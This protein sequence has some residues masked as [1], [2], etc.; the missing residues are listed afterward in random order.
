MAGRQPRSRDSGEGGREVPGRSGPKPWWQQATAL[1]SVST[2]GAI[3]G[4]A[5][6][7]G[8]PAELTTP[9]AAGL[10]LLAL[11]SLT[12]PRQAA[13]PAAPADAAGRAAIVNV[14]RYYLKLARARSAAQ[15]EALIWGGVSSDGADHGQSCAAFASLTLA[16]G[17]QAAGQRSWVT[18]GGSYPWPLHEWADVRVDPNPSS[19]SVTSIAQDAR[20]HQR[21]HPLGDGYQPRPGDWALFD[22]HVEVVTSDEGGTLHTI[23]ADSLPGYTV[24]A[25]ALAGP[26]ASHGI[27]GFVDN[28]HLPG[29]A[30]TGPAPA[31][32]APVRRRA[33]KPAP[34]VPGKPPPG[35]TT[36]SPASP[37]KTTPPPPASASIPGLDTTAA[38][39]TPPATGKTAKLTGGTGTP[40]AAGRPAGSRQPPGSAR[41]APGTP[42]P[43]A[44][45][46]IPGLDATAAGAAE[47]AK[48]ASAPRRSRTSPTMPAPN[49][50]AAI[51]G[52]AT[53]SPVTRPGAAD[54]GT[55][56][57]RRSAAATRSAAT[58][59]IPGLAPPGA[60]SAAK[61]AGAARKP[62]STAGKPSGTPAAGAQLP[63]GG[64][65]PR[66]PR[67]TAGGRANIPAALPPGGAT[68]RTHR[69]TAG[70]KANM[71]AAQRA[72][73]DSVAP[74]AIAARHRYG[75]P[76]SVTIAQA[77]QESAWGRSSLAASYHNLFGIKGSGPAGSAWLPTSEYAGGQWV[78]VDA[79]FRAYDNDAQSI[80]DH[81]ELLATSGYYTQAM[82]VRSVPDA[83]ANALTGVYATD[84][85]YGAALISLM[86]LYDLYQYDT[87]PQPQAAHPPAAHASPAS[88]ARRGAPQEAQMRSA[89]NSPGAVRA[90]PEK[91][92]L[93]AWYQPRM[94][95]PVRRAFAETASE[96][97]AHLEPL[98]RDVAG[99]A[100][101]SWMVLAACDWMQCQASPRRSPVHGEKLGQ[102]NPDGLSY[103]TKSAA[104]AQC[105]AD[106]TVLA[107]AV[108]RVD[109]TRTRPL[110]VQE[111]AEVF[112]AFRWGGLLARHGVSA[113]E[114][115][116]SVAGLTSDHMRMHWPAVHDPDP[117]DRPGARFKMPFGAV[118]ALLSLDY[119]ATR[120]PAGP[121]HLY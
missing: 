21:W 7:P 112:A 106:L 22:G 8:T 60:A 11:D 31:S 83:F 119:P 66:T 18:G 68:P 75:V 92:R 76:A 54:P 116:Y 51:P 109:L 41:P 24:N 45:A 97:L 115:P 28:G 47:P 35:G 65:T 61:P 49:A 25:H 70:G 20:E 91:A 3:T 16:L 32:A 69:G 93:A 4:L 29:A 113:M 96:P 46:S 73:I 99:K 89:D 6:A 80:A 19:L 14:A 114:F 104:L 5:F 17:A 2:S 78:T 50:T 13:S 64:A 1:V 105:A 37:A 56:G 44:T 34:A 118:P 53:P 26:P 42:R 36:A 77:I 111:L 101:I 30:S 100:G 117:P 98:Y 72:F 9:A 23:G 39:G 85:H 10:P 27:T 55:R 95:G 48:P 120:G 90:S 107:A 86:R 110:S 121:G 59:S 38:D 81:A 71:S 87:A 108:Y 12:A 43:A 79:A 88:A 67:G 52:L 94:P 15:M 62:A 33:A 102:V 63:P 58:A 82:A 74:G 40:K 84:P 57:A 103:P